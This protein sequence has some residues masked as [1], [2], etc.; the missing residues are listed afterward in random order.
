MISMK[1]SFDRKD[2]LERFV[3]DN[4]SGFDTEEPDAR[5]WEKIESGLAPP[6]FPDTSP[7]SGTNRWKRQITYD[8]RV[9][10]AVIVLLFAGILVY[11]NGQYG[12]TRDP[13]MALQMPDYA[14]E[15]NQY[16]QIINEKRNQLKKLA[17]HKPQLYSDFA[18]E[19][20]RLE[21]AYTGLRSELP[22]SPDPETLLH[23]MVRN[24][25]WQVDL[26]NQ[27]IIIIE[28]IEKGNENEESDSDRI[29]I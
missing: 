25:Q 23:A 22:Q 18:S 20:D 29:T 21:K 17:T 13:Q 8:W 5:L 4:R 3:R 28:S 6:T 24:L 27:Q 26:L 15:V 9:A 12:L 14:K 10:A 16:T 2:R 7:Q 19:L 11:I 1:K